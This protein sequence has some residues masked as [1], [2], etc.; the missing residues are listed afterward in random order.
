MGSGGR[1]RGFCTYQ[2][3]LQDISDHPFFPRQPSRY[4][5]AARPPPVEG[6]LSFSSLTAFLLLPH[7]DSLS[8]WALPIMISLG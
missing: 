7:P 2:G 5:L 6:L 8:R 4:S 3:L 1:R